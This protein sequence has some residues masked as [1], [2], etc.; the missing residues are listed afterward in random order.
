MF[1][2]LH[3]KD[4][5]IEFANQRLIQNFNKF[6]LLIARDFGLAASI[7]VFNSLK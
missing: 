3:Q 1:Y 4:S 5:R 7:L 2:T 6:P